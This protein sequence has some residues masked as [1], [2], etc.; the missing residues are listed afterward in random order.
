VMAAGSPATPA[1]MTTR[2][3]KGPI[4]L[5]LGVIRI[6]ADQSGG[7]DAGGAFRQEAR[8]LTDFGMFASTAFSRDRDPSS[9]LPNENSPAMAFARNP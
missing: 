6:D 2:P 3:P 9:F 8:R 7:A 4:C 1:P 5:R